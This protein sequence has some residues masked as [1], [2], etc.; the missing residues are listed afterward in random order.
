LYEYYAVFE[1]FKMF[2]MKRD[3]FRRND[4]SSALLLLGGG[5]LK[6]KGSGSVLRKGFSENSARNELAE[7]LAR[8][9]SVSDSWDEDKEDEEEEAA[10]TTDETKG[11]QSLYV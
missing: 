1:S 10:L 5:S 3:T 6:K 8:L 9:D 4:S 7:K 11:I 2:R